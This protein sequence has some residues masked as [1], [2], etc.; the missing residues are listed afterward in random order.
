MPWRYLEDRAIADVAF[1]SEGG[2][3]EEVFTSAAEALLCAMV[4]DPGAILP[5]EEIAVRISAESVEMLLFD[6]L[7]EIIFAKDARGLLLRAVALRVEESPGGVSLAGSLRGERVDRDR[8]E[9]LADVKA[10]TL[11]R[12]RIEKVSA[13]WE[14]EVVLDV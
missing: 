6:F 13:G 8:H 4:A 1:L 9:L 2:S 12:Y 7:Q 10:V 3:L 11:H 14:A 5:R